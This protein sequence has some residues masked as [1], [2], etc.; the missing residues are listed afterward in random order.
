MQISAEQDPDARNHLILQEEEIRQKLLFAV[1]EANKESEK[2]EIE[3]AKPLPCEVNSSLTSPGPATNPLNVGEFTTVELL[4]N[5]AYTE[6]R[7]FLNVFGTL[8]KSDAVSIPTISGKIQQHAHPLLAARLQLLNEAWLTETGATEQFLVSSGLRDGP[9]KRYRWLTQPNH[10]K[11]KRAGLNS[12]GPMAGPVKLTEALEQDG[13]VS[14]SNLKRLF[15]AFLEDEYGSVATGRQY[16]AWASPHETGLAVD[17][18]NNGLKPSSKTNAQQ[19]RT[20]AFLW[21]KENAY[22]FGFNP[23]IKEAW[24]WEVIVPVENFQSGEEFVVDGNYAVYPKEILNKG[25]KSPMY[26]NY[27]R[28]NTLANKIA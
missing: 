4:P 6:R 20:P 3:A 26:A 8:D 13:T 18:G 21:L 15:D 16:R 5:T 12:K 7:V 9:M 23:Y 17:F 1:E 19:K 14:Y 28:K 2:Q 25:P 22:R 27:W 24:H 11:F 10:Y